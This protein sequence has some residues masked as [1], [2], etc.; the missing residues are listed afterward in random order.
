MTSVRKKKIA[1]YTRYGDE[2]QN[3]VMLGLPLIGFF[4]FTLYPLLWAMG[5][6]FFSYD[7]I[8]ENTKFVGFEN[9][10]SVFTDKIYW[11]TWL[12]TFKFTLYKVPIEMVLAL[13]L[14]LILNQKL[15]GTGFFR[16]V[17]FLPNEIRF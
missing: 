16:S 10:V 9:I 5:L 6:S 13:F 2:W 3:Y 11:S 7:G 4:V 14:A 17:F 15:R 8:R 1:N 12:T